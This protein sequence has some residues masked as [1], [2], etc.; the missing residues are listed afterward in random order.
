MRGYCVLFSL[1][2]GA[3]ALGQSFSDL[4]FN[5]KPI[6]AKVPWYT[7]KP[8]LSNVSNRKILPRL[9]AAQ[10]K[11]LATNGF[12][13][14]PTGDEQ[15]FYIYENNTYKKIPTFVTTDSVMH[16]YH[17]FYDFTLR[18][19]EKE[20]LFPA[21][22]EMSARMLDANLQA[23]REEHPPRI[24]EALARNAIMFAVPLRL[25]GQNPVLPASILP[26]VEQELQRV[27]EH[28]WWTHDASGNPLFSFTEAQVN[29]TQFIPRGHYTRTE[30]FKQYFLAMM[31]YGL[32]PMNLFPVKDRPD[33]KYPVLQALILTEQLNQDATAQA[34][35]QQLYDPTVFYVGKADDLSFYQLQPLLERL[36]GA[37]KLERFDD[38]AKIA[39]FREAVKKELPAAGIQ[40]FNFFEG[41]LQGPQFRIMGQRYIPDSRMLQELTWPRVGTERDKRYFPLGLDV[42]AVLG[43]PR[44]AQLLDVVY[45]EPRYA[46]YLTQRKK[47]QAE[48]ARLTPEDWRQNLYYGWMYCL[49]PMLK[50]APAGYPA[51]MRN[52]AWQDKSLVTALGS[53][54]ELRHDTILYAKQSMVAECGDGEGPPPPIP[55]YVEP[56][57]EVYE[58]L[59][60]LLKLN[61]AGLVQ[62]KLCANDDELGESF[63]RFV[64]LTD[65]LAKVSR[66]ELLNVPL[67]RDELHA[68]ETYGGEL[69]W[70]MLSM[71]N[72]VSPNYASDWWEIEN[73]T[74]R[75]MA[76]VADVHTANNEA[77]EEAVGNAAEIWVVV[78]F[79][80]KL[81]ATRGATFTYYEFKQPASNRLTDEAWQE[82]LKKGKAPIMPPWTKSYLFNPGNPRTTPRDEMLETTQTG[83]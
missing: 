24:E 36:F 52:I 33:T 34:L 25:S 74:D 54:T 71:N 78:P 8:D 6:E 5:P 72:L 55:G 53:W 73:K 66:K 58:R 35:W 41:G 82:Q 19:L 59:S 20:R 21:V 23:L 70:L 61:K 12:F 80:G 45:K 31:W 37:G 3:V 40:T 38:A 22:K 62:R 47:L 10:Q 4:P 13:A 9:N 75:S 67:S 46:N 77:L 43:S 65:L 60:W 64:E 11:A 42:F 81:I 57:V 51:F 69:E 17:I 30:E 27:R 44:A 29:Y 63:D 2:L 68:I 76:V 56:Q 15:L 79:N 32:V 28:K 16:T 39:Q 1:L 83:C 26:R 14:L 50:P 18:Y 48:F 7:V 49:L